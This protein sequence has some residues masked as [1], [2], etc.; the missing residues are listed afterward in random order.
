MRNEKEM[1][2]IIIN[3]AKDDEH[4]RAVY[5]NGSRTNPNARKDVLRDFDIVYVVDETRPYYEDESWLSAFG[6]IL[7]MQCPDRIDA[8][9]G[10]EC[11]FDKSF[12]WLMIFTDGNRLDLHVETLEE[13]L[14]NI[15]S[16]TLCEVLLDKDGALPALPSSSDEGY[17]VKKPGAAEYAAVCNEFRWCTNNIVKGLYRY[18]I[19]YAQDMINMHV[20]P[21]LIKVL[22]WKAG[23]MN[24]WKVS[25]G[26][27]GKYLDRWLDEEEWEALL[28]TYAG[29]VAG[30]MWKALEI[31]CALFEKTA[32]FL[33]EKLGY[34]YNSRDAEGA[35]LYVG[36]IK[37]LQKDDSVISEDV[38]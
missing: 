6:E 23:L 32:L 29:G 18:E 26:K 20:R 16:D 12:C 17:F 37:A 31:M 21:Q 3:T 33:A 7:Y 30:E 22:S 24:D 15:G 38:K 19:T 28:M 36:Y 14:K 9:V 4:V 25:V 11:D 13:C 2:D 27:S 8:S 10:M 34:E 35:K 5:M 1:F